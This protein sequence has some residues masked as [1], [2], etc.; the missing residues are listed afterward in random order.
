MNINILLFATLKDRAQ[1][2]HL[3]VTLDEDATVS[4]LKTR[5][6]AEV[7]GL[8]PALPTALVAINREFAFQHDRLHEGDEVGLFPPV[9][10][11][12]GADEGQRLGAHVQFTRGHG[13]ALGVGL[14]ADIDHA[15]GAGGVEVGEG[16]G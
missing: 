3:T 12:A 5:L 6:A 13:H 16:H 2:A 9:S 4:D 8:A 10:G 15:R 11:G 14:V 1:R 7:P